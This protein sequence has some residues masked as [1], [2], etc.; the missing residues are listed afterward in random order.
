MIAGRIAAASNEDPKSVA[1]R[2]HQAAMPDFQFR[3][4]HYA[5]IWS[6]IAVL[7][8]ACANLANIQLARGLGRRRELALRSAL[9][10]SRKRLIAHLLTETTLLAAIGLAL[11]LVLTFWGAYAL[12]AS[13]PTGVAD[14]I[15]EPQLSWRVLVFALVAAT[16]CLVLVGL[17]PSILGVSSG[18]IRAD[19]IEDSAPAPGATKGLRRRYAVL[20]GVEIALA[21]ALSSLAI[22]AVR[23]SMLASDIGYGYDPR[24]LASGY[25]WSARAHPATGYADQLHDVVARLTANDAVAE[26]TASASIAVDDSVSIEDAG[27]MRAYPTPHATVSAVTTS[28]VR[29]FG[30]PIVKGRDFLAGE[31]NAVIVDEQ[32]AKL[33][34]PNANPVGAQIKFGGGKST[35]P[36]VHVV[37]V[38]GEQERFAAKSDRA[39]EVVNGRALGLVLYAPA[40]GD[41][42]IAASKLIHFVARAS[43]SPQKLPLALRRAVETWSDYRSF[44]VET[45]DEAL[46]LTKQR[47]ST[48]FIASLFTLFA[49]LGLGLAAFGVYGVVAHAVTERRRE[50]G[51]RVALGATSRDILHAVLRESVVVALAGAAGGLLLTKYGVV[52]L[53]GLAGFDVYNAGLFAMVAAFIVATASV[54]AFVP[55]LRATRIDP[56]ESLRAE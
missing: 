53:G 15:V 41:T 40:A 37:G 26:A 16:L 21:L 13:I 55:A 34:W 43:R 14:Y 11:G 12:R 28:Y 36:Y 45:M 18:R 56:T 35:R 9:G 52:L 33:L 39:T 30:Y 47:Q 32:T 42:L 5:L 38:I 17:L 49:G 25:V 4:I 27:G 50:L 8:V 6:V 3:D 54:S 20:V 48:R 7:L 19:V 44:G 29:T 1:F 31:Q 23:T 22:V 10:A 24:P 46:N 2:F 51:V